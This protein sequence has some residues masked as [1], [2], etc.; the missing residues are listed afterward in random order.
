MEI[1][2]NI[3][4]T[5]SQHV[6]CKSFLLRRRLVLSDKGIKIHPLFWTIK[7]LE[8]A[9]VFIS[10]CLTSHIIIYIEYTSFCITISLLPTKV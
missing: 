8:S 2:R 4:A 7:I 9:G 1:E 3:A 5:M 10:T 6:T